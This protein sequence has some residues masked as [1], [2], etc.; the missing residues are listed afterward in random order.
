[1]WPV[2]IAYKKGKP[3]KQWVQEPYLNIAYFKY[4]NLIFQGLEKWLSN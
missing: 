3:E 2:G 1:M 4:E